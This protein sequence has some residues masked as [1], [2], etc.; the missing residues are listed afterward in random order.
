MAGQQKLS[1]MMFLED[2]TYLSWIGLLHSVITFFFE[3]HFNQKGEPIVTSN[4][5]KKQKAIL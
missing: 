4:K 3:V 2:H 1:G 5:T